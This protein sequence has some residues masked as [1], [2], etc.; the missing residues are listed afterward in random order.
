MLKSRPCASVN[1]EQRN[2]D[3]MLRLASFKGT[4]CVVADAVMVSLPSTLP[5]AFVIA[6]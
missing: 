6:S 4:N 1:D 2:T 5:L 3:V